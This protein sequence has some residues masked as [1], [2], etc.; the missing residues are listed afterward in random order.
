M[1]RAYLSG[2]DRLAAEANALYTAGYGLEADVTDAARQRANG[3]HR[4]RLAERGVRRFEV[5]ALETG[6]ELPRTLARRLAEDG[7]EA[8]RARASV[9]EPV[10][11]EPPKPGGILAAP[12]RSPLVGAGLALSRE[13]VDWR[14]VGL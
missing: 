11:G 3:N 4:A 10:A 1:D 8:R 12:R 13:R 9:T 5:M 14:R 2:K 6:R 7:P